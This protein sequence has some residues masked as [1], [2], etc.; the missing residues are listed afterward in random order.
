MSFLDAFHVAN[1]RR[2]VWLLYMRIFIQ[3]D[4]LDSIRPR[5]LALYTLPTIQ[6]NLPVREHSTA[7]LPIKVLLTPFPRWVA[8]LRAPARMRRGIENNK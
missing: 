3:F 4:N 8:S 1:T 2:S 5:R 7:G 6:E